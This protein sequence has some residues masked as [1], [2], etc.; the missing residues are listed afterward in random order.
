MQ[1]GKTQKVD[2]VDASYYVGIDEKQLEM[3][4]AINTNS[5]VSLM[6]LRISSDADAVGAYEMTYLGALNSKSVIDLLKNY[7]EVEKLSKEA[8]KSKNPVLM[9]AAAIFV[10][11]LV[12]AYTYPTIQV[13]GLKSEIKKANDYINSAEVQEALKEIEKLQDET[14]KLRS[15][16]AQYDNKLAFEQKQLKIQN[17][18]LD[19]ITQTNSNAISIS[20]FSFDAEKGTIA[21]TGVCPTEYD[22]ARFVEA[23]KMNPEVDGVGYTGYSYNN[24]GDYNFS[25]SVLFVYPEAEKGSALENLLKLSESEVTGA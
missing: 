8:Q 3:L 23:L 11:G 9:V 13:M 18:Y 19:I 5:E 17:R 4:N 10:L 7:A 16:N 21:V 15:V 20:G 24:K 1:F 12:G 14:S 2:H 6:P 25:I 22:A